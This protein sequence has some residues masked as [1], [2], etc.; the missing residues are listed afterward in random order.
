[1]SV[2]AKHFD[3]IGYLSLVSHYDTS[4]PVS[5][6]YLCGSEAETTNITYRPH[7]TAFILGTYGQG[8]VLN[9]QQVVSPGYF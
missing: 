6:Q 8:R 9:N 7:F 5:P 4:I 1:M 2:I 3:P